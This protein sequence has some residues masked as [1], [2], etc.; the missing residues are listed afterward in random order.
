MYKNH[1]YNL[2]SQLVVE[3]RSLWRLK[4]YYLKDAKNCKKCKDLWKKLLDEKENNIKIISEI[5]K[6]HNL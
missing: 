5:L 1:I 4:K 3:H 2:M 6:S